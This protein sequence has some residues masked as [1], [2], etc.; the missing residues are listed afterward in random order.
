[1]SKTQFTENIKLK[2]K[3]DIIVDA[4]VIVGRQNKILIG[5]NTET[6]CGVQTEGN[7]IQ[8][9]PYLGIHPTYSLQTQTLLLMPSAR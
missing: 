9:L 2:K 3:E 8:R 6:K 7:A 4:S 5:E 1:M